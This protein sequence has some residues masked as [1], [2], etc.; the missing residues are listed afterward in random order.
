[1]NCL[2][3]Q[4]YLL[5]LVIHLQVSSHLVSLPPLLLSHHVCV[6]C[7]T[8]CNLCS[9][10]QTAPLVSVLPVVV[11]VVS[12]GFIIVT[13]VVVTVCLIIVTKYKHRKNSPGEGYTAAAATLYSLLFFFFTAPIDHVYWTQTTTESRFA[14]SHMHLLIC[15]L[16]SFHFA[17][18]FFYRDVEKD[19]K[20]KI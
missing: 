8:V 11:G 13:V 10:L 9:F 19:L 12:A 15:L 20:V 7:L 16:T 6:T 18:Q 5:L 17:S 4:N 3:L 14:L 1:M 2:P